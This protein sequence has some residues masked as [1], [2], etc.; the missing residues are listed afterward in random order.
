MN[1]AKIIE[2]SEE[3]VRNSW[4]EPHKMETLP[5]GVFELADG[6]VKGWK[7]QIELKPGEW[8]SFHIPEAEPQTMRKENIPDAAFI[9][10]PEQILPFRELCKQAGVAIVD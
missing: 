8:C 9:L 1:K 4:N 7:L 6:D 10:I 3:A 5:A 2:V